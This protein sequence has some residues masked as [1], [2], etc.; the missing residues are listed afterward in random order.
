MFSVNDRPLKEE[1]PIKIVVC[2]DIF[3]YKKIKVKGTF[4]V[5]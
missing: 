2:K 5:A 3:S 1:L 4:L